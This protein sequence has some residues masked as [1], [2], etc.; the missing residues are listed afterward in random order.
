MRGGG[1]TPFASLIDR[2]RSKSCSRQ[3]IVSVSRCDNWRFDYK[4][5][6]SQDLCF[7]SAYILRSDLLILYVFINRFI[8]QRFYTTAFVILGKYHKN[9]SLALIDVMPYELNIIYGCFSFARQ[10]TS[11][12]LWK[13]I[14]SVPPPPS[15]YPLLFFP[16]NAFFSKKKNRFTINLL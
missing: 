16:R 14:F 11:E 13:I 8:V 5:T 15:I 7:A 6:A 4:V 9:S 2:I 3:Y 1:V 12:L 10:F